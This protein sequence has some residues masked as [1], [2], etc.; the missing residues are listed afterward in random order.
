MK[1]KNYVLLLLI[2]LPI[3]GFAQTKEKKNGFLFEN[4]TQGTMV[5]KEGATSK[6]KFNYHVGLEKMLF[7]NNE[8][9]ILQLANPSIVNHIKIGDR[10]FEHIKD[11]IFYEKISVNNLLLYIRWHSKMTS[12]GRE[13]AYGTKSHTSSTGYLDRITDKG[14]TF[15][16]NSNEEFE[17]ESLNFFFLKIN[18]KFQRFSSVDS[19][20]KLF[21]NHKE[22]I[23]KYLKEQ[24]YNFKDIEDVKKAVQYCSQFIEN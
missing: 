14:E 10:I 23:S 21:K 13:G 11:G 9:K 1:T 24:N 8:N 18:N 12:K 3:L 20:A 7:L 17:M 15:E 19:L 6:S 4:F 22:E 16:L 2:I 5:Y